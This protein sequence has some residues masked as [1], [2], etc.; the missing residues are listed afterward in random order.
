MFHI[1]VVEDDR[2]LRELFCAVLSDHGYTP[3][4]AE[5][6]ISAF[7]VLEGADVVPIGVVDV[8]AV[9]PAQLAL[10]GENG[11]PL[12]VVDVIAVQPGEK[13]LFEIQPH[14]RTLLSLWPLQR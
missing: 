1:L 7:D 12:L 14:P 10:H 2:D 3:L 11:V 9:A 6:G 8:Q 5:D 4:P 13:P